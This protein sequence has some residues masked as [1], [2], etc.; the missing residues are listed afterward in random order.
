MWRAYF[1]YTL[2]LNEQPELNLDQKPFTRENWSPHQQRSNDHLNRNVFQ[3]VR[4]TTYVKKWRNCDCR[5]FSS[6]KSE[7][8]GSRKVNWLPFYHQLINGSLWTG[9][10]WVGA[11]VWGCNKVM[12][13]SRSSPQAQR[14]ARGWTSSAGG[15]CSSDTALFHTVETRGDRWQMWQTFKRKTIY[16]SSLHWA[17][18]SSMHQL[19][20]N[21]T[22]RHGRHIK[23]KGFT[24]SSLKAVIQQVLLCSSSA[25]SIF[26]SLQSLLTLLGCQPN[27][28]HSGAV[29]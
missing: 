1:C 5:H 15:R 10:G 21:C 4:N 11:L 14:K 13:E 9:L 7:A 28:R 25:H 3:L 29:N 12:S 2:L 23:V 20:V 17:P 26:S 27:R 24:L 22:V 19:S 18:I 6:W 8:G 16:K